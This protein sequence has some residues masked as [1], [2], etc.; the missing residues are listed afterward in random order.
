MTKTACALGMVLLFAGCPQTSEVPEA[1]Q[2]DGVNA[3]DPIICPNVS[4]IVLRPSLPGCQ[5]TFAFTV[6]NYS[7]SADLKIESLT[8]GGRDPSIFFN[9]QAVPTTVAA[10]E[11]AVVQ[12]NYKQFDLTEKRAELSIKSNAKNFSDLKIEL[13]IREGVYPDGGFETPPDGG[14]PQYCSDL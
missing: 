11:Q 5:E 10:G 7:S 8:I 3:N 6:T 14:T 9:A 12:F 4:P 2:K 13:V 1:C